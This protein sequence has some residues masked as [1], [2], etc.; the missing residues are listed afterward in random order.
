MSGTGRTAPR[1]ATSASAEAPPGCCRVGASPARP[2]CLPARPVGR[3]RRRHAARARGHVAAVAAV[4]GSACTR[5]THSPVARSHSPARARHL[6]RERA[7]A[8][9]RSHRPCYASRARS[10]G[11]GCHLVK[12]QTTCVAGGESPGPFTVQGYGILPTS[13]HDALGASCTI[14]VC[15]GNLQVTAGDTTDL[16]VA[17]DAWVFNTYIDGVRAAPAATCG[18]DYG[19]GECPGSDTRLEGVVIDFGNPG[20][21]DAM[22]SLIGL[23]GETWAWPAGNCLFAAHRTFGRAPDLATT[24]PASLR[25]SRGSPTHGARSARAARAARPRP[26]LAH[27]RSL[28]PRISTV[29]TA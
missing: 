19:V 20:G 1:S 14:D 17:A 27:F 23:T 7:R 25:H 3:R 29:V 8:G 16:A 13:C 26:R 18:V 11:E 5:L 21:G 2:L 10:T 12:F 28:R 15:S 9:A 4:A 22:A 6:L 24:Q